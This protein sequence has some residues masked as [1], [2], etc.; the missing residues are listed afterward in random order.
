MN[1]LIPY[2]SANATLTKPVCLSDNYKVYSFTGENRTQFPE[3]GSVPEVLKLNEQA[4]EDVVPSKRNDI[5][6]PSRYQA[7]QSNLSKR[8][9]IP[10][11]G[12][13]A[14]SKRGDISRRVTGEEAESVLKDGE[15]LNSS[16]ILEEKAKE[17][18][19][20]EEGVDGVD[21]ARPFGEDSG[22]EVCEMMLDKFLS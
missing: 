19:R 14:P 13:S 8:S 18:S 11:P 10:R 17:E 9:D 1:V 16:Q 22:P 6:K 3:G 15:T 5:P 20:T 12:T 21:F 2:L 7:R 4:G